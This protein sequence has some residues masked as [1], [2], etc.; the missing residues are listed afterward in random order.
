MSFGDPV[1]RLRFCAFVLFDCTA[2]ESGQALALQLPRFLSAPA[3][4]VLR[5]LLHAKSK[6]RLGPQQHSEPGGGHGGGHAR[7]H[8]CPG[9]RAHEFFSGIDWARL[10]A[11]KLSP[12]ITGSLL[13]TG[14]GGATQHNAFSNSGLV[15][16]LAGASA[17]GQS[18][19]DWAASD[20]LRRLAVDGAAVSPV[21]RNP[22]FCSVLVLLHP[23][24][25][26]P[27]MYARRGRGQQLP[28][29]SEQACVDFVRACPRRRAVACLPWI[30]CSPVCAPCVRVRV[31]VPV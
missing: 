27:T 6:Q 23:R 1:P 17:G 14:T 22:L 2:Q 30:T 4:S 9:V 13:H 8:T 28:S 25:L 16:P 21:R 12:P 5:G 15:P 18:S 26:P 3:A 20:A 29:R 31:L 19:D 24:M 7:H 10:L 11:R